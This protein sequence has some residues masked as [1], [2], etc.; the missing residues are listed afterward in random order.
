M[1]YGGGESREP[2]K[3]ELFCDYRLRVISALDKNAIFDN[4]DRRK[5]SIINNLEVLLKRI[6]DNFPTESHDQIVNAIADVIY[7]HAGQKTRLSGELV[8]EHLLKTA[9]LL[10]DLVKDVK[11]EEVVTAL[12]HDAIEDRARTMIETSDGA[13]GAMLEKFPD[14]ENFVASMRLRSAYGRNI[15]VMLS[16]LVKPDYEKEIA[17]VGGSSNLSPEE[18]RKIKGK[19]YVG[20]LNKALSNPDVC[21]VK[22]A[23][24]IANSSDVDNIPDEHSAKRDDIKTKYYGGFAVV[25]EKLQDSSFRARLKDPD[26]LRMQMGQVFENSYDR[27]TV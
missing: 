2:S 10:F 26:K 18:H 8:I 16:S 11:P 20:Y 23:D 19:L 12:L 7:L 13:F 15:Q 9:S 14:N 6:I 17:Q 5:N 1:V 25:L 21:M 27:L 3:E 24:F 4:D 22:L